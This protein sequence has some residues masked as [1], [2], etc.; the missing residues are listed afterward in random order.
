[1]TLE[2]NVHN[3]ETAEFAHR[4]VPARSASRLLEQRDH[5][6]TMGHD[7]LSYIDQQA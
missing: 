2:D 3:T 6:P 1:M 7:D 5:R 4:N